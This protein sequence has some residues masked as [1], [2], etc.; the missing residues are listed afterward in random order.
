MA[1]FESCPRCSSDNVTGNRKRG[2]ARCDDCGYPAQALAAGAAGAI[3]CHGLAESALWVDDVMNA[4]PGPIA[5][6][7]QRLRE[8]LRDEQIVGAIWKLK[9]VAEIL[10]RFP[11]CVMAC[12]VIANSTD[13]KIKAK[14]R[15]DLLGKVMTMGSWHSSASEIALYMLK[16]PDTDFLCPSLPALFHEVKANGKFAH[17]PIS[18]LL[19]ELTQWRNSA[20]AHGALRLNLE[21]FLTDLH[22]F[23][24]QLHSGLAALSA[25]KIWNGCTL[26]ADD[27]TR[28]MDAGSVQDQHRKQHRGHEVRRIS[29]RLRS[30]EREL[31]LEPYAQLRR[32]DE[33]H[34]QDVFLFDWRSTRK[35]GRDHY[36]FIDYLAG[37]HIESPG[38]REAGMDREVSRME[39]SANT[40]AVSEDQV[41]DQNLAFLLPEVEKLLT[42]CSVSKHYETPGY[43]R[44]RLEKFV[45][46]Q[47]KGV[48]WLK[49][50][51]HV[52]KSTFIAGIDPK[53]KAHYAGNVLDEELCIAAFY[54]R[55][56]YQNGVGQFSE[57]LY[58]AINEVLGIRTGPGGRPV[59]QL[60][61][62]AA[63]P[64]AEFSAWLSEFKKAQRLTERSSKLLICID[65]L[66]ELPLPAAGQ[67]S[68]AD[69][70]PSPD[71]LP[72]GVYLALTSR[73]DNELPA[74]LLPRLGS[75][76]AQAWLCEVGLHDKDYV[77]LMYTYFKKRL[78][79][80][81]MQELDA[82]PGKAKGDV[83]DL[84]PLFDESLARSGGRFLYLG[85]I[86]DRLADSTLK[87]DD[88]KN[89]PAEDQ[90]FEHFLDEIRRLHQ[91]SSLEDYFE[92]V[93]LHLSAAERAF[94]LDRESLPP[95]AREK[96][97]LG[98]PVDVL[99]RRV[100][101]HPHGQ[102]TVKLAYTLYTL[103]PVLNTWRGG[104]AS[105]T[106]YRLGLKGLAQLIDKRH[107]ERIVNL[108]AGLVDGLVGQFGPAQSA[109]KPGLDEDMQLRLRYATA[110]ARIGAAQ[111]MQ[112]IKPYA[113]RIAGMQ[114]DHAVVD[115]EAG[116]HL[117][118]TR[119]CSAT[120]G[121][122]ESMDEQADARM[123]AVSVN[124]LAKAYTNRGVARL[125]NGDAAGALTDCSEAIALRQSLQERRSKE[126]EYEFS[127]DLAT[128]FKNRGNAY[129]GLGDFTNAVA[130]YDAAIVIRETMREQLGE[131]WSPGFS[132]DL[133]M[134]YMNRGSARKYAGDLEG[135]ANDY[136]AAILQREALR[137]QHDEDWP[138]EFASGLALAYM[139]R[140]TT[141]DDA[142]MAIADTSAA[143]DLHEMLRKQ[144]GSKWPP[145]FASDL[146]LAYVN[147]GI[148][149]EASGDSVR[150]AMD[151]GAA[152]AI[153]ITLSEQ[154]GSEWSPSYA[155]S[156][157]SAYASRGS[158][159]DSEGAVADYDAAIAIREKLRQEMGERWPPKFADSLASNCRS[160]GDAR[161]SNGDH[162]GAVV[163]YD[164][165]IAIREMLRGKMGNNWTPEFAN[166][167]ASVHINRGVTRKSNG[168]PVGAV[169]DY[170]AAIEIHEK[171]RQQMGEKWTQEF[172][173]SLALAYANRGITRKSNSDLVG[174]IADYDVAIVIR[175][176]LHQQMGQKWLPKFANG[177]ASTYL[178]RGNVRK[179]NDDPTGAVTDYDAAIV[180]QE[181]LRQEMGQKW[182][183]E[184]ADDLALA[185][186]NRGI[187]RK[188][189]GNPAGALADCDAA[190]AIREKLRQ[191]MGQNWSPKFANGLASN[192]L[193]RGDARKLN[194]DPAGALEDCDAAIAIREKLR[195]QMVPKWPPKFAN[196]LA[197]NY[198]SRGDA[199]K[200]ND[201]PV[202]AVADY[203]AAIAIHENLHQEMREKWPPGF[204]NGLASVYINRGNS[205]KWNGDPV[206]ALA[207]YDAVIAIHEEL[208]KQF[209]TEWVPEYVVNLALAYTNRGHTRQSNSDT[210]GAL[211]DCDAAI[212]IREKLRKEMGE[213]CLP[214]FINGLA[215]NYTNRGDAR[216]SNGDPM[217][218][219]AD[220]DAAIAIREKLRQD[221][222]QNWPPVFANGL[223]SVYINR[224]NSRQ[225]NGD[226]AGALA[227]CDAAIAI[228][229]KLRQQM[230]Q[231]W[232][233]EFSNRLASNYTDRGNA[234]KSN[235]DTVGAMAD[236][237]TATAIRGKLR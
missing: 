40:A 178:S 152:I 158:S 159:S 234:R 165:A 209:D 233:P 156:L 142:A 38:W 14:I 100:D 227:D 176:K 126:C 130:D 146:A 232:P 166:G 107:G 80:R 37:H 75:R 71:A 11:V 117:S 139:N 43:L 134:V 120:I 140:G 118:S 168:D 19:T 60:D 69:F 88:L 171:L 174:A 138:P 93:L 114:F 86:V 25:K 92:R 81:V 104:I 82:Y 110:H 99:S 193:S 31:S 197:S 91:G 136:N 68:I 34:S 207:D 42:D 222:G 199:R 225:S 160:R 155:N 8:L 131:E 180:I 58:L 141:H 144:L 198:I 169:A 179:S 215:S 29:L 153:G 183:P 35:N 102:I 214:K 53:L 124:Q 115:S 85:Y 63:D 50:P 161:K 109:G 228:G 202:G 208:C 87:L 77:D 237:D 157:A 61:I 28:L 195:Q 98:L 22:K 4:W 203:N 6:E 188:S 217:G 125:S 162:V 27:G 200:S 147:R 90:L 206:G 216:K 128:T 46:A 55:R 54:I 5:H 145:K 112:A 149:R 73:L 12:D 106:N 3:T 143:V 2:E 187:T 127:N 105:Q 212:A 30:G 70:L 218:A 101:S 135:A 45:R 49:A 121:L 39:I 64:A 223:A 221:M 51:G 52:G 66:D 173:E 122:R 41:L 9:D 189:N 182:T 210:A 36:R 163:D 26:L 219:V 186:A 201:D 175:E 48:W 24:P 59:R 74:W 148:F 230:G 194:G 181:K 220:Y 213:K 97:W 84:K 150:A 33:C 184:F 103:K 116:R 133:A 137:N 164:A 89:L 44:R 62:D 20:F 170:D 113:E 132:N 236:Y 177:L 229:D 235:G 21:E 15:G 185:Y 95:V 111:A 10:T 72:E 16:N 56:E 224:G 154:L 57:Q 167:L 205:R 67:R 96:T 79:H 32:C 108:H 23:L 192:Y 211:A 123:P 17:S 190:I 83:A 204:A 47:A 129:L 18:K 78:A 76:L 1:Y 65:G 226:P 7:Y 94:E 231:K 172:A 191:Q 196:G 119:W 13:S 151:F